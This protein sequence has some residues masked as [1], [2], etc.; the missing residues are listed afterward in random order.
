MGAKLFNDEEGATATFTDEEETTT[1][2]GE[3]ARSLPEDKTASIKDKGDR[4]RD[5]FLLVDDTLA[6]GLELLQNHL[7]RACM[8]KDFLLLLFDEQEEVKMEFDQHSSEQIDKLWDLVKGKVMVTEELASRHSEFHRLAMKNVE[9]ES[10]AL[11]LSKEVE[12]IKSHLYLT[13]V[14]NNAF[15]LHVD[16]QTWQIWSFIVIP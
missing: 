7:Y 15:R 3:S 1:A 8:D 14:A 13:Y 4:S 2:V 9:L 6:V 5:S 10:Q 16:E 12:I 11:F